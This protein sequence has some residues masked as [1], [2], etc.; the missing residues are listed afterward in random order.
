[1]LGEG[2]AALMLEELEYAQARG[3]Q[4]LGEVIGFASSA[5]SDRQR[6]WAIQDGVQQRAEAVAGQRQDLSRT[7]S[8]T[9]TPTAWARGAATPKR[10][11]PL[12]KFSAGRASPVPVVAAKSYFGNLGAAS[13]LVELIGSLLAL[14][15]GRL[16][17]TL[18]YE[19]PDPECPVNVVAKDDVPPGDIVHQ[20]QHLAAGPGQRGRRRRRFALTSR[21]AVPATCFSSAS[22]HSLALL[23]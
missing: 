10:P 14:K 9:S 22:P 16:F 11:R 20:R 21:E 19:T 13:G 12:P 4:I 5:V 1:M 17:R 18:N 15:H 6:R 8:A 23:A 7:M 3:A 2:A